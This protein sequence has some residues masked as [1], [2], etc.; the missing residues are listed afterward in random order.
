MKFTVDENTIQ[1]G[2]AV[3]AVK[4]WEGD[5]DFPNFAYWSWHI[6]IT[7]T[8]WSQ[9]TTITNYSG[10]TYELAPENLGYVDEVTT[11]TYPERKMKVRVHQSGS[12][13]LAE[14]IISQVENKVRGTHH[15][16]TKYQ[17]GRKDAFP[18]LGDD[19]K[20]YTGNIT[21][22]Y[23]DYPHV[24]I[25]SPSVWGQDNGYGRWY[26]KAD[27]STTYTDRYAWINLWSA[28][29]TT[30]QASSA[31]VSSTKTIYDPSP[32]GYKVPPAQVFTGMIKTNN[33]TEYTWNET[34]ATNKENTNVVGEYDGEGWNFYCNGKSGLSPEDREADGTFFM[35][36]TGQLQYNVDTDKFV[37]NGHLTGGDLG[38]QG[39]VWFCVPR[40]NQGS[41]ERFSAWNA[42]WHRY[43]VRTLPNNTQATG[44][45][46]RPVAE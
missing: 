34:D 31:K 43:R 45:A 18:G 33:P 37:L 41:S 11:T 38:W 6:Y 35:P 19:Q 29:E 5:E 16:D 44:I 28:S 24:S 7:D 22:D 13:K 12:N 21:V 20:Y 3:L 46:V 10:R 23:F 30:V 39:W 9:K 42:S 1:Q 4:D 40:M 25:G 36:S 2:N 32:V 8:D 14:V 27:E 26:L 15:W 17:W